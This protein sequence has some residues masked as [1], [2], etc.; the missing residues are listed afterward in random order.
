MSTIDIGTLVPLS[1]AFRTLGLP[2]RTAER[3][4]VERPHL[5]PRV[6]RIGRDRFVQADELERFRAEQAAVERKLQLLAAARAWSSH[7]A[8]QALRSN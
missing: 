2:T 5:L 6:I 1:T 8:G 7:A 3:Y 4:V